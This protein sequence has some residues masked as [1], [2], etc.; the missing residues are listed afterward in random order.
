V[1][2]N[3][4]Y[5]ALQGY[6]LTPYDVVNAITAQNLTLPSGTEKIG[7]YE[8]LVG[9][10]SSPD[11][12]GKLN[13]NPIKSL[14]NGTSGAYVQVTLKIP[15]HKGDL[16]IPAGTLLFSSGKPVVGVVRPNGTVE[17]RKIVIN[18]DLGSKL[19]IS[20]GLSEWIKLLPLLRPALRKAPP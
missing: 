12:I 19:E 4:N 14:P 3:L 11:T 16:T 7:R 5:K 20:Q 6:A 1:E 2:V 10:N 15:G 13:A 17:I 18:H 9:L 8:Y